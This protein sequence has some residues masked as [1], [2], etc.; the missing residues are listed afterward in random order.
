MQCSD[1][2]CPIAGST[3]WRPRSHAFCCGVHGLVATSENDVIA[4]RVGAFPSVP[5]QRSDCVESRHAWPHGLSPGCAMAL[6]CTVVSTVTHAT[7]LGLTAFTATAVSMLALSRCSM[8]PSPRSRRKRPI[9]VAN[10]RESPC[11][12]H[13][14]KRA[15]L[16]AAAVLQSR[17]HS[18]L[19]ATRLQLGQRK[20][21]SDEPGFR[22]CYS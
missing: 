15:Y 9:F 12:I 14:E 5:C 22:R 4:R 17:P 2:K 10:L 8:P 19:S 6:S 3:A 1:F 13:A 16:R 18:T 20:T 21:G 7:S 11:K